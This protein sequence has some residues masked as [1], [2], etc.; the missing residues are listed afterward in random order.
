MPTVLHRNLAQDAPSDNGYDTH[1]EMVVR[2]YLIPLTAFLLGIGLM[3]GAYFGIFTWLQGWDYARGQFSSNSAYVIPIWLAFGVQAGLYSILRFR[4]FLPAPVLRSGA[5]LGTSGGA[6]V[7]TMVACC[8]HHAVD[9]LPILGLSAAAT[10]LTRYQRPLMRVS[11]GINLV[12]I[13]IMLILL[14]KTW[15]KYRPV[16]EF[17]PALEIQ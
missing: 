13:L 1:K 9:V 2:R 5:M 12:G 8:V 14:Y 4:L 16:Q 6:S 3:A 15:Q 11:L 7:A 17:E 10:F